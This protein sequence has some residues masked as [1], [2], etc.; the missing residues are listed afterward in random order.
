MQAVPST[1][2]AQLAV[3]FFAIGAHISATWRASDGRA[4]NHWR[5]PT[6]EYVD[7]SPAPFRSISRITGDSP[8]RCGE[9]EM[10]PMH[11][12]AILIVLDTFDI[13]IILDPTFVADWC[14]EGDA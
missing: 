13:S 4:E 5:K 1:D 6:S 9:Q 8:A 11:S 2:F 3:E 14:P 7:K 10:M 12:D